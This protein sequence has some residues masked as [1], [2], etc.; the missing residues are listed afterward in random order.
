MLDWIRGGKKIEE[1]RII[2]QLILRRIERKAKEENPRKGGT[3]NLGKRPQ[4]RRRPAVG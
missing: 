2:Y 1:S 3:R 4:S